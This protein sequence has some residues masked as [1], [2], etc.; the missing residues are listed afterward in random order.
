M[1]KY[2]LFPTLVCHE[3][4]FLTKIDLKNVQSCIKK[5]TDLKPHIGLLKDST[6]K[7]SYDGTSNFLSNT[8][9][10]KLKNKILD[11]SK[12]YIE[13]SGLSCENKIGN[14]WFNVQN[15]GAVLMEHTHPFSIISGALYINVDKNSSPLVFHN[16]NPCVYYMAHNKFKEFSFEWFRFYPKIGDL[17][18]F[19]S[20]LR[21]GSDNIENKTKNRTVLSFNII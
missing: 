9:L 6:S 7:T 12:I 4:N 14:S 5:Q 13:E 2:K 19:P 1:N 21:H 17:I 8:L 3:D 10:S 18:L 15:K 20:W 16:P 11:R